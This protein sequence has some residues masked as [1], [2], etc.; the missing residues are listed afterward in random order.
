MVTQQQFDQNMVLLLGLLLFLAV[1]V[2]GSMAAW[3]LVK[4]LIQ[5]RDRRRDEAQR[6]RDKFGRHGELLP[7]AAPGLCDQC[8]RPF[9][10]VYHLPS[11]RRLCPDDYDRTLG[12]TKPSA[13]AD[14]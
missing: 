10:K 13:A 8:G 11:G 9:D 4:F 6:L 1:G 5:Q 12:P 14:Q 2:I 3:M 7:P